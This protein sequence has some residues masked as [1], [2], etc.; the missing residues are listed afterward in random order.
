MDYIVIEIQMSEL[1]KWKVE[2]YI[3]LL[4]IDYIYLKDLVSIIK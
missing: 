4:I 1:F 3:K 2:I